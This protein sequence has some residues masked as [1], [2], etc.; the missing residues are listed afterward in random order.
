MPINFEFEIEVEQEHNPINS[1]VLSVNHQTVE[2]NENEFENQG[3]SNVSQ[4]PDETNNKKNVK[5]SINKFKIK[6]SRDHFATS[7]KLT[8]V[9]H[10]S[11]GNS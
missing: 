10:R 7:A 11:S 4:E 3:D 2:D 8:P 6:L 5:R 9:I 1:S